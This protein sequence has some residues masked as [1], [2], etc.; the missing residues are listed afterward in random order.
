MVA[1]RQADLLHGALPGGVD[2]PVSAGGGRGQHGAGD[3]DDPTRQH[4]KYGFTTD[5]KTFYFTIG[6]PESDIFVAD[7][8]RK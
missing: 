8:E 2:G 7:L 1:G 6:S 5:G 3:F 4:T